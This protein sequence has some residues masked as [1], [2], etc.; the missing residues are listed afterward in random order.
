[1]RFSSIFGPRG[2]PV[3]PTLGAVRTRRKA[4]EAAFRSTCNGRLLF[5]ARRT[6]VATGTSIHLLTATCIGPTA[7]GATCP[8]RT[9]AGCRTLTGLLG[10][11][12]AYGRATARGGFA[13]TSVVPAGRGFASTACGHSF[14][15]SSALM[16]PGGAAAANGDTTPAKAPFSRSIAPAPPAIGAAPAQTAP[17]RIPA[18]I[19]TRALPTLEVEAV[20]AAFDYVNG[21]LL[22]NINI[23]DC[24]L[25]PTIDGQR[26]S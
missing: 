9:T 23:V 10:L 25:Q 11:T 26:R 18:P 21:R 6:A 2:V 12:T 15:A 24:R 17:P 3:K 22:R 14:S 20:S 4:A 19:P 5:V 8:G 16:H 7:S 13:R 1:M